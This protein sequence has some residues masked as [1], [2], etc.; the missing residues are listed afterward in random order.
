MTAITANIFWDLTVYLGTVLKAWG[1]I[2]INSFIPQ[3]W[4]R[5][6][7]LHSPFYRWKIEAKK[8]KNLSVLPK[9]IHFVNGKARTSTR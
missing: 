4:I 1:F 7:L 3:N 6:A 9:V 5:Y 2:H 8:K